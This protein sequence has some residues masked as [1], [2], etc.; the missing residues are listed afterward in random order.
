M[1]NKVK[2]FLYLNRLDYLQG[3]DNQLETFAIKELIEKIVLQMD[4]LKPEGY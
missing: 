4:L 1:V 3:E 2:S